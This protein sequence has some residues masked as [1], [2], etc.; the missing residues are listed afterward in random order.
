MEVVI[1]NKAVIFGF[2]FALSEVIGLSPLKSN[3]I[4]QMV[5]S[6]LKKLAGKE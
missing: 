2:L 1:A 5:A 3:S 4:F 6:F